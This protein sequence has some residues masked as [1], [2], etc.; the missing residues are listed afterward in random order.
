MTSKKDYIRRKLFTESSLTMDTFKSAYE[1][2]L[3]AWNR[4]LTQNPASAEAYPTKD[5]IVHL[6]MQCSIQS[7]ECLL[8]QAKHELEEDHL[9]TD[10]IHALLSNALAFKKEAVNVRDLPEPSDEQCA[11][12]L[13]EVF[14][15]YPMSF[16]VT[17]L[18]K[19]KDL[20][21]LGLNSLNAPLTQAQP[22]S[23][24][25]KPKKRKTVTLTSTTRA[26][27]MPVF[28]DAHGFEDSM[29]NDD[30]KEFFTQRL[31]TAKIN[32]T[33]PTSLDGC[34]ITAQVEGKSY[35][36][37][38]AKCPTWRKY[39]NFQIYPSVSDLKGVDPKEHWRKASFRGKVVVGSPLNPA[40]W[41]RTKAAIEEM[42]E[43]LI[44]NAE[45]IPGM[46]INQAVKFGQN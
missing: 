38:A 24:G 43:V 7:L 21:A 2:V 20:C 45:Q 29:S 12:I 37:K 1:Q 10:S 19:L 32:S 42:K 22:S 40:L 31:A 3:Q 15:G 4:L 23:S 16:P 13:E 26:D 5:C 18:K 33:K 35:T 46:T 9:A 41:K 14:D 8:P 25:T 39:I 28:A 17:Q 30:N 36:W 34:N 27:T 6:A 11:E 44:L